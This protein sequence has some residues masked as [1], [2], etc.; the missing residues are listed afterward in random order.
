MT[1]LVK[2]T[3]TILLLVTSIILSPT[4]FNS[5]QVAW[6]DT[7]QVLENPYIIDH[8]WDNLLYHFSNFYGGQYSPVNTSMY[9]L[10]YKIFGFDALGFHLACLIIHLI[11]VL[12]VFF[13]IRDIISTVKP[14]F[15][16]ARV[17]LYAFFTALVFA[18]HPL[19]VESIAWISASKVIVFSCFFLLAFKCYQVY[20]RTFQGGWLVAAG[21]LYVF[22]FASKEQ[23]IILPLNL[24]AF[25]YIYGRFKGISLN[26]SLLKQKVL[27]EKVPF[28]ILA[29]AFWYFS[30][31]NGLGAIESNGYPVYQRV[32]L[33][34]H[35]L[36][37]YV[38]RAIA[39]VKLYFYYFFPMQKGEPLPLYYWG[40]IVLALVIW[41]F[42]WQHV[43]NKNRIVVFGILIFII[44]LLLVLHI[45]PLPRAYITADRFM[46]LSIIGLA[47]VGVWHI[48][49]F[50]T[51]FPFQKKLVF[52]II[53]GYL[54]FYGIHSF[55][56]TIQWK[57]SE[58][59]KK[60]VLNIVEKRRAANEY[61]G[62][63]PFLNE[64]E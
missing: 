6:D 61:V 5:F 29:L 12:L 17:T 18:I 59:M 52:S 8:S 50:L 2:H 57:D 47:L 32:I 3:N 10:V 19:Q 34:I 40:Y 28:F 22:G 63:H 27:I 53:T 20:M 58:T 24:L 45:L 7:W 37:E 41:V 56:R 39:P 15:N 11:N 13:I 62:D 36:T 31:T 9:V 21:V 25:D 54:L 23:A 43:K 35:S 60:N 48:D 30:L 64:N 55:Y 44:N 42:V 38:F 26:L 1:F 4:L 49:F 51:K 46:Y 33:G 16:Y 14:N